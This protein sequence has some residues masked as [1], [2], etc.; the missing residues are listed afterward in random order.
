MFFAL[1]AFHLRLVWY[2]DGLH[3]VVSYFNR[4]D[5]SWMKRNSA[6][7]SLW[8]HGVLREAGK[9]KARVDRHSITVFP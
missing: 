8:G 1:F 4:M 3:F 9:R 2:M 5:P 6:Q 7:S